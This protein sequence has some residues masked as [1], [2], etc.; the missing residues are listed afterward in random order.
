MRS[1]REP[2]PVHEP[3]ALHVHAIDDLRFIRQTMERASAFT[4]VPGWGGV[5]M[6]TSALFAA[7]LAARQTSTE[8]WLL[9]W[10][11]EACLA[12]ILGGIATW[13]K[14]R[15]VKLP[16][17]GSAGRK[18]L[19]GLGPPLI[20]GAVLTGALYRSGVPAAIPG[21]WMLMYGI[22]ALSAGAFSVR[23]VPVMGLCFM[24]LGAVVLAGPPGWTNLCMAFGFGV[25]HI[26]CGLIIARRH[27]G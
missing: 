5:L 11:A 14:A 12:G 1:L 13:R 9:V 2:N 22:S 3:Q 10:I 27:G 15:A 21:M 6:G 26:V 17:L 25:L 19:F 4:A 8:A 24:L 18:F 23:V 16:L 20:A 7:W